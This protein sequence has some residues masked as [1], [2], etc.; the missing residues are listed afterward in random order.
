MR[1][2]R[3]GHECRGA[4]VGGGGGGRGRA[5]RLRK[6]RAHAAADARLEL[7]PPR[8]A[9]KGGGLRAAVEHRGG[10]AHQLLRPLVQQRGLRQHGRPGARGSWPWLG[11]RVRVWR[12]VGAQPHGVG[13]ARGLSSGLAYEGLR[14][15]AREQIVP[16]RLGGEEALRHA[17][18]EL[19]R[20]FHL[21]LEE[22]AL[23]HGGRGAGGEPRGGT[24]S[25]RSRWRLP[26]AVGAE[27]LAWRRE[28][29]HARHLACTR[30]R[31]R[32]GEIRGDLA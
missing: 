8:R 1:R 19:G 11:A 32:S 10:A 23:Q 9:R 15:G 25:P 12:G 17:L 16:E 21:P 14:L 22:H 20:D 3:P 30:K 24:E 27:Q 13:A 31:G 26:G 5:S 28:R 7:C 18:R 2:R 4:G 6:Q 29:G